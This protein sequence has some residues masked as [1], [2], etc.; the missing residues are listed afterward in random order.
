M[1][2]N[3]FFPLF[4]SPSSTFVPGVPGYENTYWPKG[5]E[6]TGSITGRQATCRPPRD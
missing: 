2:K 6:V 4:L 5:E 1:F 3:T